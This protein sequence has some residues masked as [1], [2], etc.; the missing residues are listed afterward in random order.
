MGV[1]KILEHQNKAEKHGVS[2]GLLEGSMP[3]EGAL[4]TR[5]NLAQRISERYV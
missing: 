1:V 4:A 2:S 5:Q 3:V